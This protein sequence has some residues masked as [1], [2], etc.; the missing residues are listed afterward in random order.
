MSSFF[1]SSDKIK[2]GQTEVSVPAE[3]GMN[4][5]P[6][7]RIAISIP[8]T[9]KFI[10]LSQ[11][12][13]KFDVDLTLP[14]ITA[15]SGACRLQLDAETGLHSLIRS[16]RI[17]TGGAGRVLLE[18][19]EGYDILT[20]LRFDYETN[21]NLVNKRVLTEGATGYDPACRGTLGTTKTDCGNCLSSAYTTRK[22]D[23]VT[24]S[25]SFTADTDYDFK[26]VKGEL[27]LNTGL[28]RNNAVFPSVLTDGLFCEILLR[29]AGQVFRQLDSTLAHRRLQLNPYFQSL[30]GSDAVPAEWL[31]GSVSNVFYV[32]ATTNNQTSLGTFP[33]VVGQH[34][35]WAT[36]DYTT[37][38]ISNGSLNGSSGI[39]T[40]IEQVTGTQYGV[41]KTKVTLN[42]SIL[43]TMVST[44]TEDIVMVS[45]TPED[46]VTFNPTYV[47]SNVEML[48]EQIEVPDGYERSMMSMMKEGGTINYDYRSFTNYKYSQV[49][50]DL[51]ANIR[52]PL[53]ESR[54]TA[55]LC[56]P[57]DATVY[58]SKQSL[59]CSDTY[60][61]NVESGDNNNY[62]NRSGLVGVCDNLQNY[63][64]IYDGKI[65]PSRKVDT[66]K[67]ASLTSI[68]QQW[69]IEAEKALA[70]SDIE[71]MSFLAFQS[72][73]F[74][75]RALALGEN[76][77]YD[78]R[79]KDFN[80]QV[81]YTG[82]T[83]PVKNHLWN[84]YVSHVRRLVIKNGGVSVQV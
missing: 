4:F 31:N 5:N 61:V 40:Q 10:D 68:S 70:M 73:F 48:V 39:I 60:L 57:T 44:A 25:S 47:V 29:D 53:L 16:V 50:T 55:I 20:A 54:A 30:N 72:N 76:A 38:V 18:E 13:L 67:I 81:E 69:C 1:V 17:F 58:T 8:P 9:S 59:S 15:T 71:P 62:S 32:D 49:K 41:S 36:E 26:T 6:G 77:V 46:A 34:I 23:N 75:G 19:I 74:I 65:N 2:V 51:V 79:G 35:T 63:Q 45:S 78:A 33:F 24:L 83:A 14:T 37:G 80:L 82:A 64:L 11:T 84:N 28:F 27:H 7:G 22:S 66:A 12:R 56:V 3:N 43:N 42:A 52:L 21:Q